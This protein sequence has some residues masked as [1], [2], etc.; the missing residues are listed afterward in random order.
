MLCLP[1]MDVLGDTVQGYFDQE[2]CCR[3]KRHMFSDI[4]L[5]TNDRDF[6]EVYNGQSAVWIL[7]WLLIKFLIN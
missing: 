5:L 4:D 7:T 1:V 2:P 3:K 6:T